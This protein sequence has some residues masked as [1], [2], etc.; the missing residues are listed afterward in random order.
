MQDETQRIAYYPIQLTL[1]QGEADR[2]PGVRLVPGM[3]AEAFIT[4]KSRTFLDYLVEPLSNRL[5]RAMREG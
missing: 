4:T 3:P 1:D 5:G 2:L